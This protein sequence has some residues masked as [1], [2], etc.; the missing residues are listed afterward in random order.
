M[1]LYVTVVYI[2]RGELYP[3]ET[4]S[5]LCDELNTGEEVEV[6]MEN[7]VLTVLST[8]KK[9]SLKALGDVRSC[10]LCFYLCMR[11]YLSLYIYVY[12]EFIEI[13]KFVCVWN[14]LHQTNEY[15]FV[16]GNPAG[17]PSD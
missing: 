6:D 1:Y 13:Y 17:W 10:I 14:I 3:V 5:R 8:G 4:E 7:D 12:I 15:I 11:T 16:F 2:C 9:Y